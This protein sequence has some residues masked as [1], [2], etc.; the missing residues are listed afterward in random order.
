M[1]T[2]CF[3]LSLGCL[4]MAATFFWLASKS[5]KLTKKFKIS[6]FHCLLAGMFAAS[7]FLFFPV[8]R[9]AAEPTL[10]GGWRAFTLSVF[11][12]MQVFAIGGDFGIIKENIAFCPAWLSTGYQVWAATL[13][14][15]APVFTFGVVLSLFKILTTYLNYFF[16][17][18]KETYVFSELNEKSLALAEDIKS[19]NKNVL[20]VFT[21][22]SEGKEENVYRLMEG[23]KKLEAFCFKKDM[24]TLNFVKRAKKKTISLFVIGDDET[25][26]LDHALKLIKNYRSCE[27]VCI[28]VFCST[29]MSDLLLNSADKGLVKVRRIHEAR[30]FVNCLLNGQGEVLFHKRNGN[31]DGLKKI[32][33]V[34]VGMGARGTELVKALTWLCQMDGYKPEIHAFDQDP[35]A[36]EKF[37]ALAPELMSE[38]YN[39]VEIEGEAQY[40]I[41]VHS[42][43]DVSTISFVKEL[44]KINEAT[45]VFVDL[46]KD[47][48]NI[49]TAVKLRMYFR[50]MGIDPIIQ[51][52]VF[53]PRQKAEFVG[54]EKYEVQFIGGVESF[55]TQDNITEAKLE[56]Q[57]RDLCMK[58]GRKEDLR[59]NEHDY[60][61]AIAAVIHM[62]VRAKCVIPG[63]DQERKEFTADEYSAIEALEHR[64]WNAY[65]RSEGYVFG[66]IKGNNG[67]D[68]LA[69]THGGLTDYPSLAKP[70]DR[71]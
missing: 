43:I 41:T 14:V 66:V 2:T 70:G 37:S 27:N 33:A 3:F 69:K 35:L 52:V 19:K 67:R 54:S 5:R 68:D 38:D 51:A 10:L 28:Y 57:A 47:D 32:S 13:F 71:A 56:K 39:G 62:N 29:S 49:D 45:Y 61:A 12:S 24:L 26:N 50:R 16:A 20:I 7:L 36:E 65:M 53:D 23:I 11:N 46:G 1:W 8:Q 40:K 9:V 63:A 6:L 25:K 60:R 59:D 64:R 48:I 58:L 55:Y 18:G 34:V 22:V 31:S 4:P 21:N 44:E 17:R 42:G 30:S 15:S